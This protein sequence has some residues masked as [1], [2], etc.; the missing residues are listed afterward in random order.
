[1][2][3]DVTQIESYVDEN[4]AELIAKSVASAKSMKMLNLQTGYKSS[5]AVTIMETEVVYQDGN[6]TGRSPEGE[7]VLSQRILTVGDIIVEEDIDLKKLNKTYMQHQVKAGSFE[8]TLPF[9][10]FYT[11]N[12]AEKIALQN[13]IAIWRGDTAITGTTT[14]DKN[15]KRFDGFL[16]IFA[17]E[18]DIIDGNP[19]GVTEITKANVESIF[20]DIYNLIPTSILSKD[21]LVVMCG[22]DTFRF[23]TQAVKTTNY[24]HYDGKA[25]DFEIIIP[26]TNVTLVATEGL[27]GTST[28]VCG[29]KSNFVIGTDLENEEERFEVWYSKDDRVLKADV[30]FKLGT[31]IQHPSEVVL[32]QLSA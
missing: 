15:L 8:D 12:K 19:S 24:N 25:S 3:L 31:Q 29:R 14:E 11:Q 21:D 7:T 23:F 5:G 9:E 28:I 1:M 17:G 16:K 20:D 27:N 18:S 22:F 13:E 32:F 26:G 30:N 10:A 4:R 6:K 2:S